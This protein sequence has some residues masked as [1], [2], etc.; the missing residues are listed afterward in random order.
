LTQAEEFQEQVRIAEAESRKAA[1]ASQRKQVFGLPRK[2]V[3]RRAY[4]AV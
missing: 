2:Q 1:A 3:G 4:P